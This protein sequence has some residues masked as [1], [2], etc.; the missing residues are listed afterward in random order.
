MHGLLLRL[1]L[2]LR[3]E[4]GDRVYVGAIDANVVQF[5]IRVV[6]ELPDDAP[7]RPTSPEETY[8]GR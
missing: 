2:L 8:Q 3:S 4:A 5:A 1:P 7:V 6:R